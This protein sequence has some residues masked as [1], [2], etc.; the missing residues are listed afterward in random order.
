MK[1]IVLFVLSVAALLVS[2]SVYSQNQPISFKHS[3]L[4]SEIDN[5]VVATPDMVQIMNEDVSDEKNGE[6]YKV[7]RILD[8]N[9]N[10]NNCGTTDV[11]A[12]GTKVWRVR[13]ACEGA[14]ALKVM[15]PE[16]Y[17]PNGA[18]LFLYNE[19][20]QQ[21]VKVDAKKNPK[22]GTYYSPKMIQGDVLY[23]E[24]VQPASVAGT[25]VINIDGLAYFYRG[26]DAFVGYYAQKRETG[27]GDS[28]TCEVNVNCPVGSA[29]QTQK[30]GVAEIVVVT[31]M[32]VGFCSGTLVNNTSNDGTPYFLTADHCGGVEAVG[33]MSRWEFNFNFEAP[34]CSVPTSEPDY[35]VITGCTLIARPSGEQ[36]TGTDFLLLELSTTE[37]ELEEIG[38]YY[39]GWDRS[40]TGA[41]SGSCI[42]HPFGDIKKISFYTEQLTAQTYHPNNTAN[43][44]WWAKWYNNN[45]DTTGV[46][47]AG[48]S[49]SPLFNG[50]NKLIVGT[51]TGGPSSC[52][53]TGNY[54]SDFYGRFDLHWEAGGTSSANQLKP[55]LDPLNTDAETCEG[56]HPNSETDPNPPDP[57]TINAEFTGTPT[58]ISVGGT[59]AFRDASTGNPTSWSWSFPGG[60]PSTSTS[61]NPSVVYNTAG[62]YNVSLTISDGTNNDTETKNAYIT[63]NGNGGMSAAFIASSYNIT[64]GDCISFTDM[65]SGAITSWSWSFQGAETESSTQQ[66]PTNICYNT[67]G[68]YDVTLYVR[69]SD[70]N[71]DFVVCE[72]CIVVEN[73]P[74][75]PI[76]EFEANLTVLP[77]GGV[78]RFTN[79]SQNGPFDQ[80]AW[81]F[82]GGTPEYSTDSVPPMIAYTEVGTY[83][84]ELSCSKANGSQDTELKENYIRVVPVSNESPVANFTSDKVLIRPGETVNFIDISAN[85]P[86]HWAWEFEGGTPATSN[87]PNPSVVY[88]TPGLYNVKLTVTNNIGT[89]EITKEMYI[90]VSESDPCTSVP[91]ADFVAANRQISA[92]TIVYF[93]NLSTNYVAS[94]MWEFEGG[95]PATSN[96]FSPINGVLY[97]TPGIYSVNLTVANTCGY[98]S[99]R[100]ASYIYVYNDGSQTTYTVT[101]LSSDENMGT[102]TGGGTFYEGTEI[103]ISATAYDGYRFVS[104]NDG[105]IDNPRTIIVTEGATYTASF[106]QDD[107]NAPVYSNFSETACGSYTWNDSTY[108]ES[109][110]YTQTFVA[111]NSADSIVTLHLTINPL[112]R[113]EI[114]VDGILDACNPEATS[115]TLSTGEYDSYIWSNGEIT[116]TIEVTE[117]NIYYVEVVDSV[118]CH[119]VSEMTTVG[120]SSVLTETPQIKLVGM[121]SSGKN[122]ILWNVSSTTGIAGYEIYREDNIANVYN[123]IARIERPN[124]RNYIDLTSEPRARAYRYKIC[125]FDECGSRSPLSD[126]HKTMHLT[127]N[128][129]VGTN[130]NLIWSHYEGLE[131][132][133]Y[134]IY[135]GTNPRDMIIIG[136]IPSTLNSFTDLTNTLEEG[137]YYRVEI[138][139]NSGA[140]D[141]EFSLSSNIVANEFVDNYTIT[142]VS[143]NAN[144]G[145][146]TGGG[147]YPAELDITL[148]AIPNAGYEFVS[149]SDGNTENPRVITVSETAM[150]IATIA[151]AASGIED[152]YAANVSI[153]PNPTNDILNISSSEIISSVEIVNAMGQVVRRIEV[154]SDNLVCNVAE[155]PSGVYLVRVKGAK[156]FCQ[157]KFI[158]EK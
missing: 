140:K 71:Y 88:T 30:K 87:Q 52:T 79:L 117:P 94:S 72:G 11:L 131:F 133:T 2:A 107:P 34:G 83:D 75:L 56:R 95:T 51:M 84:V 28:E 57:L 26:V 70:N 32:S 66:N 92:G 130:W 76:A 141:E 96:D 62:T 128:R 1:K 125:S 118:G 154:N 59:V 90:V 65:S 145:T 100:K 129:G 111:A 81:H 122:V 31:D 21:V 109:G 33:S 139:L 13:I 151:E 149:W 47:E 74:A 61:Q 123:C 39:N 98:D 114:T 54:R 106:V 144:F 124:S 17:I 101:V 143:N 38:A 104:W 20:R 137:M 135:R 119:G 115:V 40:T 18:E 158:K 116:R 102:V 36:S 146:V 97:S 156:S 41:M 120:Y 138:V 29:W 45:N 105:N 37:D 80:W 46:I 16:F 25:P 153:F 53:M 43:G 69:D 78:V 132:S 24:Y 157:R 50:E 22:F 136:E 23:M 134:K 14:K 127:I 58:T 73:N 63:V 15:C 110:D 126:F 10:M 44:H 85:Y 93:E 82:E 12:D 89:N 91:Q 121:S 142:A 48:S 64:M 49:G 3:E 6:M 150:Y 4:L 67:P 19:N 8:V 35:D 148:A 55:W 113:P 99:I 152:N 77:V 108:T 147:T 112:P 155:L 42:H 103:Q 5:V 68:T 60:T 9:M 86:Y 27:F 7:A